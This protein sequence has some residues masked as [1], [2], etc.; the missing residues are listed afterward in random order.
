MVVAHSRTCVTLASATLLVLA[1]SGCK[2]PATDDA[3]P[4]SSAAV[5]AP[6]ASKPAA[7]EPA[8]PPA[9]E[10]VLTV[11]DEKQFQQLVDSHRGEVVLVDFWAT[12]CAPCVKHFPHTVE[13]YNKHH[14]DGLA[15]ITVNF[16]ELASEPAVKEFLQRHNAVTENLLSKYDGVGTEVTTAFD[17][18]GVLP[19]YRLYDRAGQLRYRWDEP[20]EDLDAKVAE[21]LAE[22]PPKET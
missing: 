13:L 20:P 16:D 2:P 15:A 19:H 18:E 6:A 10:V 1:I 3:A 12:W 8:D 11:A 9:V 21:L 17:F 22:P 7:S 14:T 4:Q 5:S